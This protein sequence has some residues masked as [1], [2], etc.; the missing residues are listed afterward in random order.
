MRERKRKKTKMGSAKSRTDEQIR[1]AE[2][3]MRTLK[4]KIL[5]KTKLTEET[6]KKGGKSV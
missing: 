6:R 3:E 1:Q 4:G 5:R 2:V